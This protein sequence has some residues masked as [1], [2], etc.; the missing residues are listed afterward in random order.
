MEKQVRISLIGFL[1]FFLF[2]LMVWMDK[3]FW[4][5]PYLLFSYILLLVGIA[6][7]WQDRAN[8]IHYIPL[9]ILLLVRC[10]SNPITYT[11]IMTEASYEGMM[12]SIYPD[13][14]GGI[15]ILTSLVLC[16]IAM[17]I[18]P[19]KNLMLGM[20]LSFLFITLIFLP[21]WPFRF[22]FFIIL[23]AFLLIFNAKS[24]LIPALT[25]IAIF[26][27]LQGFALY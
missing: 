9:L 27:V 16:F 15:E 1:V 20:S 21:V 23:V 19:I 25:L 14:L 4:H 7:V 22:M 17:G 18:K 6:N 8:Y 10:L 3:G 12:S 2:S 24:K 11:F 13:F 5:I 26:D